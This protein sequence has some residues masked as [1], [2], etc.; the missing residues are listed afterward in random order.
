MMTNLFSAFD[1]ST[2]MQL[3]LN[4]MSTFIGLM[5]IQW[6]FWLLP[7]RYSMLFNIIINKLH[8]EF[9]LLLG[10]NNKGS[11]LM[12]ITLFM[13]IIFNNAM[14]LLPYVFTSSSHLVFTMAM[15][16]PLWLSIMMF[17][18][19]HNTNHMF[20]H[21]VPMGTPAVLMPFMVLIETISNLIRPG[22]LAV[23][24]TANMIAGHLL[25]SLLGNNSITVNNMILPFIVMFQMLLMM[26]ETAVAF[27]QAY[28]FSVLST[29][30]ASEV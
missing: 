2:S 25:M 28:V 22:S 11:T 12:A 24:L 8:E 21:L 13:F 14:G 6:S 10:L 30:Y 23:R 19:I 18:W 17:G 3:S 1:P 26:F 5:I 7:N 20:T 4:W 29:L 15:A 27:I 9:K 16:L